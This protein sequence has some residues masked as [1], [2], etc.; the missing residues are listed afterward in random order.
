MGDIPSILL[1][2]R[3]AL[4]ALVALPEDSVLDAD[5]NLLLHELGVGDELD[6]DPDRIAL[7]SSGQLALYSADRFDRICAGPDVCTWW[8][9]V[10]TR[11]EALSAAVVVS[12]D[13]QAVDS[14]RSTVDSE[15]VARFAAAANALADQRLLRDRLRERFRYGG[16]DP[17]LRVREPYTG[18]I[19][20]RQFFVRPKSW[21]WR[22]KHPDRALFTVAEY[23]QVG[24]AGSDSGEGTDY[25]QVTLWVPMDDGLRLV[26][27]WADDARAVRV[28][29]ELFGFKTRFGRIEPLDDSSLMVAVDGQPRLI[30]RG[31]LGASIPGPA[32]R[33]DVGLP[34]GTLRL[35]SGEARS[36]WT[37]QPPQSAF[38]LNEGRAWRLQD[39]SIEL[40]ETGFGAGFE[41]ISA[42]AIQGRFQIVPVQNS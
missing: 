16:D 17:Y 27:A 40:L 32:W 23:E 38:R 34:E 8:S 30:A 28:V 20:S 5:A 36:R 31:V 3:G 25:R 2:L 13:R 33:S 14:H 15:V 24:S 7:L 10:Q 41:V 21:P 12:F 29:R 4:P 35:Y 19:D 22:G 39:T 9:D 11:L 18:R 42:T 6:V 1:G 26:M 37:G